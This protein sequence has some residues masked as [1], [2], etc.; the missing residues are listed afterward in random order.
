MCIFFLVF[1]TRSLWNTT[2]LKSLSDCLMIMILYLALFMFPARTLWNFGVLTH[3]GREG[4]IWF[5]FAF[6]L[7]PPP[8]QSFCI[9]PQL[10]QSSLNKAYV[11]VL[12]LWPSWGGEG[13]S[14]SPWLVTLRLRS[15]LPSCRDFDFRG[16]KEAPSQ[17]FLLSVLLA[18]PGGFRLLLL[19]DGRYVCEPSFIWLNSSCV[20]SL[21][22]LYVWCRGTDSVYLAIFM[23][24]GPLSFK[25]ELGG[26]W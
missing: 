19:R 25:R 23:G 2:L 24:N 20:F 1:L 10:A 5:F 18:A 16:L 11:F 7:T 6:S 8:L 22:L 3:L 14:P 13:A 26:A 9:F 4:C 21:P 17:D 12:V 15:L